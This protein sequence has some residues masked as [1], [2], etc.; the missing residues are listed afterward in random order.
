MLWNKGL[1]RHLFDTTTKGTKK[2]K[3]YGPFIV[4][5]FNHIGTIESRERNRF[6]GP[7]GISSLPSETIPQQAAIKALDGK[8]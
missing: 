6:E 3:K 1:N 2:T 8:P 4:E 5:L 7:T